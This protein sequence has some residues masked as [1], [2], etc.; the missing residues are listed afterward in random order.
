VQGDCRGRREIGKGWGQ[1][2]NEGE[3]GGSRGV[4]RHRDRDG[5]ETRGRKGCPHF[6][7]RANTLVKLLRL[8]FDL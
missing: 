4:R 3:E 1:K 7:N 2:V 5:G 8:A 6:Q